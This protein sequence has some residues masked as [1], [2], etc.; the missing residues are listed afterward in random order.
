LTNLPPLPSSAIKKPN[1][2][3]Q[4]KPFYVWADGNHCEE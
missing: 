4:I 2:N 1:I 3:M